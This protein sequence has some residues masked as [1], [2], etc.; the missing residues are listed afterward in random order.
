MQAYLAVRGALVVEA[1]KL[2][3]AERRGARRRDAFLGNWASQSVMSRC[4]RRPHEESVAVTESGF[5]AAETS[6]QKYAFL[7][8]MAN[9]LLELRT[10]VHDDACHVRMFAEARANGNG[11]TARLARDM[12]HIIDT[13]HNRRHVDAWCRENCFPD[14]PENMEVLENFPTPTYEAVNAQLSPLAHNSSHATLG[15]QFHRCRV[16]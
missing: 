5:I 8:D 13:P 10:V 14:L 12:R 16:C 15:V 9:S 2:Q 1:K 6:S 3:R 11:L 7:A 4:N